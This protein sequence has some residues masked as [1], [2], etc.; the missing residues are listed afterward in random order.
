M[1]TVGQSRRREV[2]HSTALSAK[3]LPA[4]CRGR[5]FRRAVLQNNT[6][7]L[8]TDRHHTHAHTGICRHVSTTTSGA[9]S[10]K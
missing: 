5:E 7:T 3:H 6:F 10:K 1:Q 9:G 8:S 4:T 2:E